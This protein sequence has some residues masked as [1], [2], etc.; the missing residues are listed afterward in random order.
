VAEQMLYEIGDPGAYLLPDV[1]CDFTGVQM[2]QAGPDRVRVTGARGH[3]PSDLYKVSATHADGWRCVI[4]VTIVGGRAEAKA[5]RLAQAVLARTRPMMQA[6]GFADYRLVYQEVI[7]TEALYG[8]HSRV[9]RSRE[10]ILRLVV[11]HG[12][13]KA[14]E[15]IANEIASGGVSWA[16]G[17]ASLGGGRPRAT[18]IVRL[19]SFLWPK[20]DV[21]ALL[22]VEGDAASV[23]VAE[24]ALANK[25]SASA[26]S[27]TGAASAASAAGDAR[28][29]T[30]ASLTRKLYGHLPAAATMDEVEVPLERIAHGRSGDKGDSVNIGLIARHPKWLPVLREQL[31]AERVHAY[32]AP[33]VQGP[34]TRFDVPGINA[35]NFL[36][37]AALG[38]GGMASPRS[39]PLGK[40]FAQMLLDLPVRVPAALLLD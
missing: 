4:N 16:P 7:G 30:A 19:F 33:L 25:R 3:A 11:E 28:S 26:S 6:Q 8:P 10:V 24:P 9:P 21:P 32:F 1:S 22:S 27:A 38:G 39:D 40:G 17:M 35:F 15:I 37:L 14:L 31:T 13:P 5:Q 2:S 29:E 12:D 18:P 20:R 36:L 34:V 23:V